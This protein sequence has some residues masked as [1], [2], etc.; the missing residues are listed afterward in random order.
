MADLTVYITENIT[1]DGT[2]R[3]VITTQKISGINNIDNRILNCPTGS[4]TTIFNLGSTLGA[5]SFLTSSLQYAR[6]TNLSDL[7]VKLLV[8]APTVNS[9]F[10]INS[11]S[12]FFLSTSKITGSIDNSF[13]F[14]DIQSVLIEPS[15]SASSIEYFIATT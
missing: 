15:G 5:G 14:E 13:T 10:L 3:G 12:S 6:I 4:Q 8:D 9:C 1:L 2:D 11:G 7:P